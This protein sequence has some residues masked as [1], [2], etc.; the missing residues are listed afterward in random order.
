MSWPGDIL[1]Q[2]RE[3]FEESDER[4]C[5]EAI[6]FFLWNSLPVPQWAVP[7]AEFSLEAGYTTGR[8]KG[9]PS[10]AIASSAAARDETALIAV[11]HEMA[12][13]KMQGKK[14][15]QESA[16]VS[17][18]KWFASIRKDGLGV[19]WTAA[20]VKEQCRRAKRRALR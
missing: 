14:A 8:G 15:T 4:A 18:A 7:M 12:D 16:Y 17:V 3:K 20:M 1:E 11:E 6:I 2:Y 10:P 19:G 13:M 5:F 9:N